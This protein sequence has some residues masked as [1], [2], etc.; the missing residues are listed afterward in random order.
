MARRTR[1]LSGV[2]AETARIE[3]RRRHQR[4]VKKKRDR[5]GIKRSWTP[6]PSAIP[7]ISPLVNSSCL[8]LALG[9]SALQAEAG[10][11]QRSLITTFGMNPDESG[12]RA[13][14]AGCWEK[15]SRCLSGAVRTVPRPDSDILNRPTARLGFKSDLDRPARSRRPLQALQPGARFSFA[16]ALWYRSSRRPWT[17][18][19]SL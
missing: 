11:Y 19:E 17:H 9:R 3:L 8:Y 5:M 16:V 2:S 14:N 15:S 18:P 6:N 4:L 10:L 7:C 12:H 1:R 13:R